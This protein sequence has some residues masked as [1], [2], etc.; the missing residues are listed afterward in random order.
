MRIIACITHDACVFMSTLCHYYMNVY[1]VIRHYYMNVYI[2]IGHYYMNVYIVIRHYYMNVYIV[3]GHYYMNVYIV[4]RHYY[5]N[6]YI[7]M[8]HYYMNVY[9]VIGHYYM[10]INTHTHTC[11]QKRSKLTVS[12]P[13]H[14]IGL[15]VKVDKNTQCGY[16]PLTETNGSPRLL[17]RL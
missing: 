8:C 17:C 4:I 7:V 5:M 12:T 9:I 2:V 13:L 14:G 16:R 1:I 11:E 10:N 6:V 15:V 3:I